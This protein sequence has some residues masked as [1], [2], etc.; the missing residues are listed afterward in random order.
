[1]KTT[2]TKSERPNKKFRDYLKRLKMTVLEFAER[3]PFVTYGYYRLL[4]YGHKKPSL[5]LA[6]KLEKATGGGIKPS[7]W[8]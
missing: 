1:M 4:Y 6:C 8:V 3:Y 2:V 5:D 7:D